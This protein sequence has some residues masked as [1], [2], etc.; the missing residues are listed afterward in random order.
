MYVGAM[1]GDKYRRQGLGRV[2]AE[3][4]GMERLLHSQEDGST[5]AFE[6]GPTAPFLTLTKCLGA[7]D[8]L[9]VVVILTG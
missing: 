6:C 3:G 5:E 1:G 2:E 8:W 9:R 4:E 7:C